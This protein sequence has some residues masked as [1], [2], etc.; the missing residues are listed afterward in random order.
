MK[1]AGL[2]VE[3]NPFHNGHAYHLK[4]AIAQTESEVA[5]ATMSGSFLQRGEPAIVS[6]ISR[7]RMALQNGVDIIVELP[8][9]Y[10]VQKAETFAEGAVSILSSLGCDSLFFGSESGNIRSFLEAASQY[11]TN[12]SHIDQLAQSFLK[13]GNSY[14]KAMS[15]ALKGAFCS[16]QPLDLSKPNNILGFHYVKAIVDKK[17]GMKPAT[18]KRISAEFHD[19]L[20]PSRNAGIA[21]ATSIRK[22]LLGS[23][24]TKSSEPYLPKASVSELGA[25][26]HSYQIWHTLESYFPFLKYRLNSMTK[27][28]LQKI[29]EVEEGLE[30]RIFKAIKHA[31]SFQEYMETLKTK[32]YTWTR[33]QRMTVHILT[34][35]T[36]KDVENALFESTVPCIR[37]LGFSLKGKEYLSAIKKDS[38]STVVSKASSVS[39]PSLE[40][41]LKA[42]RV[43]GAAISEPM[44]SRFS[45]EEFSD[46]PILYDEQNKTFLR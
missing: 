42:S 25:Y 20:L 39:H 7:T 45:K 28:D 21:S 32:R 33:L 40:L 15:L 8:Y 24:Q 9:V 31:H 16:K 37:L 30:N 23:L 46:L 36:K 35:T 1:A 26:Y 18:S 5:I 12:R 2:V 4:E 22:E 6:K 14:P 27:Q 19:P 44:Q 34:N 3:Y 10:A 38:K 11:N 43:Y 13:E 41:D 17:L 29:Y